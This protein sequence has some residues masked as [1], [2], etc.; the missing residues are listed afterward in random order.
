M[1]NEIGREPTAEEVANKLSMPLEKAQKLLEIAG[2]AI[3][4]EASARPA[5]ILHERLPCGG[6]IDSEH[7]TPTTMTIVWRT[8]CG[9]TSADTKPG[10][11]RD[12]GARRGCLRWLSPPVPSP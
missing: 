9:E 11:V 3:R 4:L 12:Q 10:G 1:L 6:A 8:V 5:S 2:P 7:G